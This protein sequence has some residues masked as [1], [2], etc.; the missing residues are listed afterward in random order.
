[1]S[2]QG[3]LSER[4]FQ[5]DIISYLITHG[6]N[7]GEDSQVD[8]VK[9]LYPSEVIAF[10]K[11]TQ[12][13]VWK[14]WS[15]KGYSDPE[16]ELIDYIVKKRK[17]IGTLELLKKGILKD[18][19]CPEIKLMYAKPSSGK[20]PKQVGLYEK[21]RFIVVD[22]VHYEVRQEPANR[23]DLMIFLNGIP[24]VATELKNETSGSLKEHAEIQWKNTRNPKEPLLSKKEGVLV[25]MAV[26]NGEASF[27]TLLA[28]DKTVFHP[29]NQGGADYSSGNP[30]NDKDAKGYL[31][32][33]I[34][35]KVWERD[36]LLDLISNFIYI[37]K[38]SD[39]L[40]FPRY[41]QYNLINNIKKDL[42]ENEGN[43]KQGSSFLIQHSAGSGKTKSIAWLSHLLN[44]LHDNNDNSLFDGV[45]VIS[46]KQVVDKQLQ[47]A[48]DQLGLKGQVGIVD[49][50]AKQLGQY[51]KEGKRIIVSTV[52]KFSYIEEMLL[53]AKNSGKRYAII[54]DEAHSGQ[55]GA[56]S[57]N[58]RKALASNDKIDKN[59]IKGD[60]GDETSSK[61]DSEILLSDLSSS[62][63]DAE[64]GD[65]LD[66]LVEAKIIKEDKNLTFFAF[67]ATPRDITIERFSPNG[68]PYHVYS[69]KQAIAEKYIL[70]VLD[71][72]VSHEVI[73]RLTNNGVDVTLDSRANASSA[74]NEHVR[75]SAE[76]LTYKVRVTLDIMV[77]NTL[78]RIKGE[79]RAMVVVGSRME[80]YSWWVEIN[81]QIAENPIYKKVKPL[82]A[83]TG[84]LDIK[85]E[86]RQITDSDLNIDETGNHIHDTQ[87]ANR[88]NSEYNL[89]IV[90]SKFQTGF[91]QP[92]LCTM[93]I[94]RSLSGVAAVQTLSRLNRSA[95]YKE[96]V[97]VIDFRSNAEN[98]REAFAKYHVESSFDAKRVI[99][100]EDLLTTARQ[101]YSYGFFSEKDAT[102]HALA[103][104][105]RTMK[106]KD[107]P[108]Y[109][110]AT[111]TARSIILGITNKIRNL[112]KQNNEVRIGNF[113]AISKDFIS[114]YTFYGQFNRHT[115]KKL[116]DL[117]TLIQITLRLLKSSRIKSDD[118]EWLD[119]IQVEVMS[120]REHQE[121]MSDYASHLADSQ[122]SPSKPRTP[123]I[124]T[125]SPS[126]DEP[127]TVSKLLDLWNQTF[128][129]HLQSARAE[130]KQDAIGVDTAYKKVFKSIGEELAK[131]A[132]MR[133]YAVGKSFDH[134]NDETG[135]NMAHKRLI[136]HLAILSK[137]N[138]EAEEIMRN[139][140]M[141]SARF[142]EDILSYTL[143]AVYQAVTNEELAKL[144]I[145][146]SRH[147]I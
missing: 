4:E 53:E 5:E 89:L 83:F 52:Q 24:V 87:I 41:H 58:V 80:V 10:I 110:V 101:V 27:A 103:H 97:S 72:Y 7:R 120:A 51:I 19:S 114:D 144:N 142:K 81:K 65:L 22:E 115:N 136:K 139:Y 132:E 95:Q 85:V 15:G 100:E 147:S 140:S 131:D 143:G 12:P 71:N 29:F 108:E 28:K 96:S 125:P 135:Q 54:I 1:M 35:E 20:N 112:R 17:E 60:K 64:Q 146:D 84:S 25:F 26:A 38:K 91:D 55:T 82:A 116:V 68:K 119:A 102:D 93:I 67:T 107:S 137:D 36:S 74:L 73:N 106:E 45:I 69:M 47:E 126:L 6:Y 79:G 31:T 44:S 124:K 37:E 61:D 94:D 56:N 23:I 128:M 30:E 111:N 21:N 59:A 104:Y 48:V 113:K 121:D 34:W 9:A 90:A 13:E 75:T 43:Y 145:H 105:N 32:H 88:F 77:N 49:K 76:N 122:E 117:Y 134:F 40:I 57:L 99:T 138:L 16:N 2:N 130:A 3:N 118:D 92:K 133:V 78:K 14:W 42:L 33:Y 86:D 98:V 50:N 123:K 11:D 39:I 46:D 8:R 70:D 141:G 129:S 62:S 18:G 66:E 63:D 109:N 127:I